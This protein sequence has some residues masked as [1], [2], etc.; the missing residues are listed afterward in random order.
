MVV[1]HEVQ[2][3][4]DEEVRDLEPQ[5]ASRRPCLTP[6]CLHGHVHLAEEHRARGVRER[7]SIREPE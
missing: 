2:E 4:V 7:L 5:G 1:A 3:A 6:G